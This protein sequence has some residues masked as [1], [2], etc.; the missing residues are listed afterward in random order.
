MTLK[1]D[2][3]EAELRALDPDLSRVVL[4]L[5]VTGTLSL[6]GRKRFER[7]SFTHRGSRV[8]HAVAGWRA[9]S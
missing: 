6:T 9:G 8:R 3:L 7:G 5:Q 1:I 2:L 4:D